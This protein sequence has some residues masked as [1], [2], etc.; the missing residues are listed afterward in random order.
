MMRR[1]VDYVTGTVGKYGAGALLHDVQC[2][3][4]NSVVQF[5]I[6][7]GI[8][9]RLQDITDPSFLDDA[10]KRRLTEEIDAYQGAGKS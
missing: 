7:K 1:L 2:R 10:G 4:V 3:L 9:V 8:V 6:L 5:Q